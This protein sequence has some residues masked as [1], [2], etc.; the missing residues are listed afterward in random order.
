MDVLSACAVSP[1]FTGTAEEMGFLVSRGPSYAYHIQEGRKQID[2]IEMSDC[3]TM[4]LIQAFS[5]VLAQAKEI[6]SLYCT[7]R[8]ECQNECSFY[9]KQNLKSSMAFMLV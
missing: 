4:L 7:W 2:D 3:V 1:L 9:L 5:C 6:F 8:T